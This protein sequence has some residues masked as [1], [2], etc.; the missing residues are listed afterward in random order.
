[1]SEQASGAY[2]PV[3]LVLLGAV[4]ALPQACAAGVDKIS[5]L[6]SDLPRLEGMEVVTHVCLNAECVL[7]LLLSAPCAMICRVH[8]RPSWPILPVSTTFETN[9]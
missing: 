9:G 5:V 8:W 4:E 7:P 6:H 2:Q 3:I 1:M